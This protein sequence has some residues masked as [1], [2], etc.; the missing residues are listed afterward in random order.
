[1]HVEFTFDVGAAVTIS[2][3]KIHCTIDR[4]AVGFDRVHEYRVLYWHDGQRKNEWVYEHELAARQPRYDYRRL[5][6]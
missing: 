5:D 3:A 2:E 6:P 1:M 4:V